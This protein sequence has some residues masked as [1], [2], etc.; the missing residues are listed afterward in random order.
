M[1]I[2]NSII[3]PFY[4]G[5]KFYSKLLLSI[6][7][8][9]QSCNSS[10]TFFEII[11]IIDSVETSL[12]EIND[13]SRNIFFAEENVEL[14]NLKN[15]VNKG[16]ASTRNIGIKISKG[17]FLHIID[18]DDEVFPNIYN[19]SQ[20]FLGNFN[21][22]LFNG[23]MIYSTGKFNTHK[24][25]YLKPDLTTKG[26]IK[27]DFIRSPGQ[28]LFSK[29]LIH[30]KLFPEPKNFK[31]ADD[32][33]FWLRLFFENERIIKPKYM[34]DECYIANIHDSNYSNDRFNLNQSCL[35]NW[36]IFIKEVDTNRYSKIIS[37]DILRVNYK[38]KQY[39][40]LFGLL[41]G[42]FLQLFFNLKMSKIIRF[43][44]KRVS[45]K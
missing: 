37:K 45:F 35:E 38:L 36:E 28:V 10:N 32:R 12:I 40:S 5:E 41:K 16:V 21:F 9:V 4:N 34:S 25:Y 22:L 13:I 29:E 14:V 8:A 1:K 17:D 42:F 7:K 2:S 24:I 23:R 19:L 44:I 15:E 31:G 11:T 3:I 39:D 26:L 33:F 20:L 30:E 6:L 18:Q 27:D 43:V